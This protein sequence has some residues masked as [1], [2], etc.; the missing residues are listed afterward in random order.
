M[1]AIFHI[2]CPKTGT[3]TLQ[4]FLHSNTEA[5]REQGVR[6]Q[7]SVENRGSQFELPMTAF[8]R[9][10]TLLPHREQRIRYKATT[11]EQQKAEYGGYIDHL[12]RFAETYPEPVAIF[13]SEHVTPWLNRPE[14]VQSFHELLTE[15]FDEVRYVVYFRDPALALASSYSERIKRGGGMTL[16]EF[17]SRQLKREGSFWRVANW[18]DTVGRENYDVRLL[19]KSFLAKG[20][21]ISDFCQ[22][23]GLDETRLERPSRM[24][25]ALS[26]VS[27]EALRM[28]NRRIPELRRD[29]RMNPLR[30]GLLRVATRLGA[31]APAIRLNDQQRR[32]VGW[33]R[34]WV[35]K[36]MLSE[37]FPDRDRLWTPMDA[38]DEPMP[39]EELRERALEL[40]TELVIRLR[41]GRIPPLDEAE[42]ELS[43]LRPR[44]AP[45]ASGA[46]ESD[47]GDEL[48]ETVETGPE[49]SANAT[50]APELELEPEP[51]PGRAAA[52]AGAS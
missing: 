10:G 6:F 35:D 40:M 27:A 33:K 31:E 26:S 39:V 8:V 45:V 1:K 19:D 7:R 9:T 48:D 44:G 14:L 38:K 15:S 41:L 23:C 3:T 17:I 20:D 49:E 43:V 46:D 52:T 42:K 5:L 24:N 50:I 34:N 12:R 30:R 4:A 47:E 18:A 36:K 37:F 28:L 25:E 11:L 51:D 29:G 22:A 16:D 32:R 2:G 21:L 13:S